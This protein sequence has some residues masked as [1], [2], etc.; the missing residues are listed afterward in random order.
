MC[1]RWESRHPHREVRKS[2]LPTARPRSVRVV[3]VVRDEANAIALPGVP[4]EV[5]GTEQVVYTDVDG[6][7]ILQLPPARTRSRSL[8]EG[9]QEKTDQRRGGTERTVTLDVGL[10][11]TRFAETVTVTAQAIDVETSSAEAQLIERKQAPVITDNVGSQEMKA[12]RR[13]RRGRRDVSA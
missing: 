13:L 8:L 4:V 11:M 10:T 1:V 3:G 2:R 12:E 9:Y 7:Y 5:V 6:R